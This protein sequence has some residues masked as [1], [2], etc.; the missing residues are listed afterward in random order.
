MIREAISAV[1]AGRSL[2]QEEAAAVMREIMEEQAT[3]AQLGAFL[4]A[5]HLKGETPPEI[6]GMA[7]VMREKALRVSVPGPLVDTCGTGGDGQGSF[8][9]STAA[10][11]VAAAVGLKVAKHG[12]RAASGACGSADVLEALGVKIDLPPAGVERC[13]N[14]VGIGFMF[15]PVFHPAM[16]YAGPVR[17]EI[18]IRTVFNILGPLTNPAQVQ[19]QLVGVAYPRLAQPMAEVLRLL[20]VRHA[21]VAHGEDGLDELT[22]SGTTNGWEVRDGAV[23][24]WSATIEA[25]GLPKTPSAAFKGGSKEENAATMRRLFQGASGAIRNVVLL[26]SGAVLLVADRVQTLR[27]GIE[28]AAKTIDS[29][30]ALQK[31]EALVELSQRLE[32]EL[33]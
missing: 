19:H 3:P 12:N 23:H 4:T 6:A 10:A 13:I 24:P 2:S 21:I 14:E 30:A 9:I 16:R 27:Q 33:A 29:G 7:A 20:G 31:L 11:F 1:V 25:T 17:R 28:L 15:A 26:N 18:G 22:L 32:R 8:N 5:L